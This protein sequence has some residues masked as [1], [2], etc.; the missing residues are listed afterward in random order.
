MKTGINV[1]IVDDEKHSRSELRYLLGNYTSIEHIEEADCGEGGLRKAVEF[2]PDI[3]FIDI[4]MG[5]TSGLELA[6]AL[7]KM[8]AQPIII[9]ATAHEK[10][11]VDSYKYEACD[12]ILKPFDEFRFSIALNRAIGRIEEKGYSLNLQRIPVE[13][14]DGIAYVEIKDILFITREDRVTIITTK[15]RVFNTNKTI[16]EYENSL[17]EYGFIRSHK[18]FL[19]NLKHVD[20]LI[21]W[22]NG[23]YKLK[24]HHYH[25]TIPVSR[26]Y[27]T[28]LKASLEL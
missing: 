19:V 20:E 3:V 6:D 18:S 2:C 17:N 7:Q 8:V 14:E 21:D 5:K 12:Y 9:F 1:L 28:A 13:V 15:N 25:K 11:A 27:V 24:L 16:K 10:Y 22:F 26:N 23:A 4:Q